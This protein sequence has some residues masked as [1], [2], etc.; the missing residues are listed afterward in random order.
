MLFEQG[1]VKAIP[2]PIVES[3]CFKTKINETGEQSNDR[4][5]VIRFKSAAGTQKERDDLFLDFLS[6]L[7]LFC[8]DI[9]RKS[10][11]FQHVDFSWHADTQKLAEAGSRQLLG[12]NT[13]TAGVC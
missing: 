9:E 11:K 12:N 4:I 10:G 8:E 6:N 1:E 3:V 2:H 5:L 7:D 13:E